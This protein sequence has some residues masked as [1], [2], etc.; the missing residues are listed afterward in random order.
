MSDLAFAELQSKVEALPF[1]QIVLL[2]RQVDRI[3]KKE[4]NRK[5]EAFVSEGLAWLDSIAG[6]VPRKIDFE[7][8]RSE[9]RDEKYGRAD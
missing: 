7:K 2:K 9:W 3:M 4:E 6:S 8:E 5:S 1:Y